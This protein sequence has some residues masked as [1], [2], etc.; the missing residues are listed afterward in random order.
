MKNRFLKYITL[1]TLGFAAAMLFT[2]CS[3]WTEAESNGIQRPD[4]P[5]DNPELYAKYIAALN[6][7]KASN[8]Q[9]MMTWFDNSLKSPMS[10]AQ[11][12]ASV[13]DSVDIV[14][15]LHPDNLA[16][17]E[18]TDIKELQSKG[19]KVIFTMSYADMLTAY[20]ATLPPQ[21]EPSPAQDIVPPTDGFLA[22]LAQQTD[23]YLG[24]VD[25][26][27][28]D[29]VSVFY[30]PMP[31]L[32]LEPEEKIIEQARQEAFT[33]K[34]SAWIA[35]HK[36]KV[37]I[38]EG[39]PQNL[40]NKSLLNSCRYIVIRSFTAS[41]PQKL[42]QDIRLVIREGV[43]TDRFI[44]GV[45]SRSLDQA[46]PEEGNFMDSSGNY[47]LSAA[48]E[49]GVWALTPESGFTKAGVAVYNVQT[50]YYNTDPTR[51]YTYVREAIL[52][53]NPS[54]KN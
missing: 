36:E 13:P 11:H 44:T 33:A 50:E 48:K 35:A 14:S 39:T 25:K 41:T 45:T 49:A 37:F 34:L 28:Y 15:L 19:T 30:E 7:Y 5:K 4:F 17:W 9:V 42:S 21:P 3:D 22:Y 1:P 6:S 18:I 26:Y 54:P 12:P 46:K 20:L 38:F 29:G 16:S 43:P 53:M 51:I 27:G 31:L 8:H 47:T 10:R 24:L 40:E 32:F 2:A 52:T 23:A